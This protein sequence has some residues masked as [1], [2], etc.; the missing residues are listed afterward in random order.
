[1]VWFTKERKELHKQ[2]SCEGN[3]NLEQRRIKSA[4]KLEWEQDE[5]EYS[6]YKE[7]S[8]TIGVW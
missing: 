8:Y 3:W 2:L 5:V 6:S 7:T 1:M 4:I